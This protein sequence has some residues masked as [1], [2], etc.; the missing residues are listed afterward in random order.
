M[1]ALPEWMLPE[2]DRSEPD[3]SG[4]VQAEISQAEISR[5]ESAQPATAQEAHTAAPT[6]GIALA[7]RT[8]AAEALCWRGFDIA[9]SMAILVFLLPVLLMLAVLL[10]CGDPGPIFYRH[11]RIGYRGRYFDCLKFRSMK[12][13]GDALLR[14]HLRA[15]PAAR[16]EWD[17]TRKLRDDPRVTKVG[18]IVRRLSL[19]EFPQL[20]NVLRGDMSLVGP[21]PIVEEEVWRYGRH[22]E[23]YCLVRPG[24]TGLWQTSGRSDTSYQRRVELDVSYVVRK[25]VVLDFWLLC[26]TVPVVLLARGS[27]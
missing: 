12:T 3:E 19:D 13:D 22:F 6:P 5:S 18:A 7:R 8:S 15:N 11:R 27:Y 21:R 26:K 25:G 10:Y 23:H 14:E 24:L 1:P 2:T 4:A 9:A 16:S 20:V 17:A